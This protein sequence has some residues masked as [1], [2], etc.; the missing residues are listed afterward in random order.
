MICCV[1]L[2]FSI[3]SSAALV[4]VEHI[5]GVVGLNKGDVWI[6]RHLLDHKL[7]SFNLSHSYETGSILCNG[8][9]NE[10]SG[11]SICFG[12]DNRCACLFL[13]L[14]NY[15]FCSLGYLLSNLFLLD[16]KGEF[17]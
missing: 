5:H 6:T 1:S 15:E 3:Y 12:S 17:S 9:G 11:L 2:I 4:Q 7:R 10:S 16:G 13:L 8:I 14:L